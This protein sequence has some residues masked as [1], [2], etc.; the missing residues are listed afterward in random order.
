M[1][2]K[3]ILKELISKVENVQCNDYNFHKSLDN[4][5]NKLKTYPLSNFDIKNIDDNINITYSNQLEN[6]RF[7]DLF[8][9]TNNI[10]ILLWLNTP[11]SGHWL[12]LIRDNKKKTIEI[13]D[14]YAYPF[15]QINQKLNSQMNV[16]PQIS[17]NLITKSGY[18]AIFNKKIYQ[19][20]KDMSDATCGKWVLLRLALHNYSLAQ[21][22]NFLKQLEKDTCIEPLELAILYTNKLI[23]K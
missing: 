11:K 20:R 19:D 6:L 13:F 9:M 4:L 23:K 8:S 10:G 21:F 15:N 22:D 2:K 3:P 16:S 14:S 12:G 5:T 18:K 7:A 1:N 17:L